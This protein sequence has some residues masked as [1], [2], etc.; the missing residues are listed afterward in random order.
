MQDVIKQTSLNIPSPQRSSSSGVTP[1]SSLGGR[2]LGPMV[3]RCLVVPG[4]PF[5]K[6]KSSNFDWCVSTWSDADKLLSAV[7][8]SVIVIAHDVGDES[9]VLM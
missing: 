6:Q 3:M 5:K 2:E 1:K 4:L 8:T 9:V 7:A